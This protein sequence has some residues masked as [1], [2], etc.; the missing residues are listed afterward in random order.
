M[1][2]RRLQ[3]HNVKKY[4]RSVRPRTTRLRVEALECR[5]L[6]AVAGDLDLTFDFDGIATRTPGPAGA[7]QI[8]AMAVQPIK[9]SSGQITEEKTI[10][11]GG[12]YT[13]ATNRGDFFLARF[14]GNGSLDTTFGTNGIVTTDFAGGY[15]QVSKILVTSQGQIL[16]VGYAWTSGGLDD[17]GIARYTTNGILDKSFGSKGKVTM[18]LQGG[19]E[20]DDFASNAIL[21]SSGR[22]IV[23]GT[24]IRSKPFDGYYHSNF[25]ARFNPNGSLDS[26]FGK[27][28]KVIGT[29]GRYSYDSWGPLVTNGSEIFVYGFDNRQPTIAKLSNSGSFLSKTIVPELNGNVITFHPNAQTL[30]ASRNG[31]SDQTGG[32]IVLERYLVNGT[33]DPSFGIGGQV[34]TDFS[35]TANNIVRDESIANVAFDAQE[36]IVVGGTT[37][38]ADDN[39]LN[40]DSDFLVVRYNANGALDNSFGNGG[41]VSTSISPTGDRTSQ[42]SANR[43]AIQQ[44]GRIVLCGITDQFVVDHTERLYDIALV[45]YHGE[46]TASAPSSSSPTASESDPVM[47]LV[48]TEGLTTTTQRRK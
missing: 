31:G 7:S 35:D 39:Y 26:S 38:I 18:Q 8:R 3:I 19:G 37:S 5:R 9:N 33:K 32:D 17:V 6:M 13:S 10:V 2:F 16:A 30:I 4:P 27:S 43:V 34:V 40:D 11:A 14:N 28:G 25:I 36:R 12:L 22:I 45:R 20:V 41:H 46:T 44:D 47:M 42:D 21:D 23:T 48:L 24:S 29:S 15:D 1:F